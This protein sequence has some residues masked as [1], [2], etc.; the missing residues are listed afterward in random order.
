MK[1][2]SNGQRPPRKTP[3]FRGAPEP[4]RDVFFLILGLP[5]EG[6]EFPRG[7]PG[8]Q[9]RS[10]SRPRAPFFSRFSRKTR[11]IGENVKIDVLLK[12]EH[13]FQDPRRAK[14][15]PLGHPGAPKMTPGRARN[16]K[17]RKR[18]TLVSFCL[19]RVAPAAVIFPWSSILGVFLGSPGGARQGSGRP[20]SPEN[21]SGIVPGTP[22]G[23]RRGFRVHFG[24]I[25]GRFGVDFG[26]IPH[27][28]FQL[29]SAQC[30][31]PITMCPLPIAHCSLPIVHYTTPLI[32]GAWG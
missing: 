20:R 14:Y 24:S 19:S 31:V 17:R 13:H 16:R 6:L 18:N 4:R 27:C 21:V 5:R 28:L 8:G 3:A 9:F 22:F 23:R 10:K 2:P 30:P 15:G 29:P 12:R 1:L 32:R 26:S 11:K 25:W 7:G